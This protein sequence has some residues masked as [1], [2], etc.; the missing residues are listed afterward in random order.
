LSG[1]II[2]SILIL[3]AIYF[4]LFSHHGDGKI[5][6]MMVLVTAVVATSASIS[7]ENLQD[8][9]AGQMVGA[10]P[11]KQQLVLGIGVVV[12]AFVLA[13][14]LELL[15]NAYGMGGVFPHSGMDP[16]QMLIAPQAGLMASVINGIRTQNL[17][18]NMIIIGM[19]I[20]VLVI[21]ADEILRKRGRR[22]PALAVG[23][24][25]YLPPSIILSTVLGS[26]VKFL[27]T[28]VNNRA[29]TEAHKTKVADAEQSGL[30]LACGLVAGAALMG[31][32][33]AVPFVMMGSS[34][35]L[36]IMPDN[37]SGLAHAFGLIS[38][39]ALAVWVYKISRYRK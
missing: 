37:L 7:N 21:I 3:G 20:A 36:S 26:V 8:L 14:V 6:A 25:V 15:F 23:L 13:P 1:L 34:N 10:T 27:A 4:F 24:G 32:V 19:L 30:L 18:W 5:A 31:V 17:P 38:F 35:A 11:R 39:L 29:K 22:L 16:S 2:L 9:K 28:R 33:L 12:S